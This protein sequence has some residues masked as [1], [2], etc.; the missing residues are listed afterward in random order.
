M[1]GKL[2]V[3]SQL[4]ASPMSPAP[5]TTRSK[6][7]AGIRLPEAAGR[8]KCWPVDPVAG[9]RHDPVSSKRRGLGAHAARRVIGHGRPASSERAEVEDRRHSAGTGPKVGR[10]PRPRNPVMDWPGLAKVAKRPNS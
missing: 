5:T 4:V 3:I 8:E 9:R 1:A 10:L 6:S 2:L 7:P